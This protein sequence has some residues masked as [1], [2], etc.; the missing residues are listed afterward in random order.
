MVFSNCIIHVLIF[1]TDIFC[2]FRGSSASDDDRLDGKRSTQSTPRLKRNHHHHH[3]T[4]E[5][6]DRSRVCIGPHY[7]VIRLAGL[8]ADK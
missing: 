3:Q 1:Y 8:A 5:K 2:P 4:G 6:R 7:F